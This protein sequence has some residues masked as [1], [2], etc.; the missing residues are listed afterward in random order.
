MQ[1]LR[2]TDEIEL[3]MLTEVAADELI[4]CEQSRPHAPQLEEAIFG[5]RTVDGALA[6]IRRGLDLHAKQRGIIYGIRVGGCLAGV[7]QLERK[8]YGR[9]VGMDYSLAPA[10]RGQGIVTRSCSA[11]LRYIFGD[12][13]MQRAEIWVDV[14]HRKSRAIPERLG[15]ILEGIHRHLAGYG[16]DWYG[17]VAVYAQLND[18]WAAQK[19]PG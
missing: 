4:A 7:L 13:D 1:T 15:F 17:D 11:A 19:Q 16:D 18:E 3:R 12:W 9:T 2:V 14:I 6:F 8:P 10:Y 5:P